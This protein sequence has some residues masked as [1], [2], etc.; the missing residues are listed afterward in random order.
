AANVL[1]RSRDAGA[2]WEAISPDLTRD[3]K[4][5]MG[6]S[7]GPITKDNTGVE[8]Y[9]TIFAALES[10]HEPGVLWAGSDDGLL[11]LSRDDGENWTD[12][13]PPK[14]PEWSQINSI[15]AHPFEKGGLY[16]A[17]TRYR[18]DD[19]RPSLYKTT[20]YGASWTE[21][22]GGIDPQHFTR[23][24]RAD[25]D[26]RGLLYA[27]TENG[28]YVSFDDGERWQ[29]LQ[30]KLPIVPITDLAVKEKDLVAATQGRGYWI[31]DDLSP[32]HQLE[33]EVVSAP[34]HL[35]A[36]RPGYRVPGFHFHGAVNMGRNP[37]VGVVFH[38]LL[39]EEPSAE[40]EVRLEI[41]E[42][43]G[44]L[45]RAYTRKPEPGEEKEEEAG[46]DEGEDPRQLECKQGLNRFVW[47]LRYPAAER[48]PGL[49][50]WN[51]ALEG[52]RAVPGSYLARLTVGDWSA[53]AVFEV[54]ADPR[55]SATPED[56]AAQFRFLIAVR[57]KL[58]EIHGELGRIREVR[59]QLDALGKRLAEKPEAEAVVTAAKELDEKM[60]V[61]EEALYQTKNR[62]RQDPLNFP[63]RLNDKLG[64][65]LGH[66]G[67]GDYPPTA[68]MIAV[69]SELTAQV[70]AELAKLRAIWTEDL[71]AFNRLAR[72]HEIATVI[73]ADD[74]S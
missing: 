30:L 65:L 66:A 44:E 41:L 10:P 43:D 58:S 22:T 62:S 1:F 7:G 13:T 69:R 29:S 21:I 35:F 74:E 70:D 33:A 36:P 48:F 67:T 3:D 4:S 34:A 20:D 26:R 23:V 9:C 54:L 27:G 32:L 2:S 38:Y 64:G 39:G 52:P 60:T 14:L 51:D 61:V 47:D 17:A 25:P 71:P 50:L 73:L 42:A 31:L 19:F 12:V 56:F 6:P 45:I 57:D 8:Y 55:N 24:V 68:S 11:H 63:I 46:E 15:E 18:L 49:I 40:T 28:V 53:E 59:A 72:E 37:P 16:L 5:K